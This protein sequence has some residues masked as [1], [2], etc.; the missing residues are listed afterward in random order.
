MIPTDVIMAMAV[1]SAPTSTEVRRSDAERLRDASKPS[2]PSIFPSGREARRVTAST[3]AGIAK[4]DATINKS[5]ATYP[6]KGFP[7]TAGAREA[8]AAAAPNSSAHHR[9]RIR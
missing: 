2:T 1:D 4:A 6:N 9:S 5:A 7:P 3:K 8:A